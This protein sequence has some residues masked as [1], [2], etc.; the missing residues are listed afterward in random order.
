M[1]DDID[2]NLLSRLNGELTGT[3][4][5]A[6]IASAIAYLASD[7]ARSISGA[8]LLVDRVTLWSNP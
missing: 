4:T 1:A 7:E 5:Q 6:D 3:T 2:V 8:N